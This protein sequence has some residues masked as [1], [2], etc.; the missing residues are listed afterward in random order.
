MCAVSLLVVLPLPCSFVH[1]PMRSFLFYYFPLLPISTCWE[2]ENQSSLEPWYLVGN[3]APVEAAQ[4]ELHE[5]KTIKHEQRAQ[6]WVG[7]EE[8]TGSEELGEG[9]VWSY[10]PSVTQCMA[11][12]SQLKRN[13]MTA[14]WWTTLIAHLYHPSGHQTPSLLEVKF[15]QCWQT[16]PSPTWRDLLITGSVLP[17]VGTYLPFSQVARLGSKPL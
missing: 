8:G 3:H 6:S 10:I 16:D 9:W 15:S 17:Q 5:L 1:S 12:N 7:R 13:K 11:W 2:Q 14:S 4:I